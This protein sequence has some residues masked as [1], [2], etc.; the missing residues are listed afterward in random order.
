MV[1][2]SRKT[3]TCLYRCGNSESERQTSVVS[4]KSGKSAK[5]DAKNKNVWSRVFFFSVWIKIKWVNKKVPRRQTQIW[6]VL[7]NLGE[8]K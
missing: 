3:N 8:H 6:T 5:L 7:P 1:V 2:G 4:I